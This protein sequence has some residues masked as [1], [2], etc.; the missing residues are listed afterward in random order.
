MNKNLITRPGTFRGTPTQ[1]GVTETANGNPQ[2]V[3]ELS[4]LE[5]YAET[6][7]ELSHFGITEPGWVDWSAYNESLTGY[8]VL[9]TD[10]GPLLNYEQLQKALGWD[11]SS[12]EAL[13]TSDWSTV[14]ILFRVEENE[15]NG[16]V[17][18]QVKWVDRH[19]ADPVRQLRTLDAAALKGLDGKFAGRLTGRKK[20]A[21]AR[22]A[23]VPAAT[24]AKPAKPAKPTATAK[25]KPAAAP[26]AK[27]PPSVPAKT[28]IA[29]ELDAVLDGCTKEAAWASVNQRCSAAGDDAIGAAWVEVALGIAE[30]TGKDESDFTNEEWGQVRDD[31]IAQLSAATAA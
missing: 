8:L 9:F 15:Y 11:G 1:W 19:D 17:S 14:S 21:P 26:A 16:K 28:D 13:A 12:F 3:V 7:D 2:F 25:P 20:E 6:A 27:G 23:A 24:P 31:V 29:E 30:T 10:K 22:V 18:M 5:Y 4:A